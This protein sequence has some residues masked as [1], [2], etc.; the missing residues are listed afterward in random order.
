M[1]SVE[2]AVRIQLVNMRGEV[3]VKKSGTDVENSK[4]PRP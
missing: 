2:P 1:A 3:T 4:P